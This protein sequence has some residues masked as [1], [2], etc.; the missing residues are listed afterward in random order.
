MSTRLLLHPEGHP[1][2]ITQRFYPFLEFPAYLWVTLPNRSMPT[3][4]MT[5]SRTVHTP[6]FLY[7]KRCRW[8]AVVVFIRYACCI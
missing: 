1:S 8:M 4:P 7:I 2:P 6:V 3:N 5:V